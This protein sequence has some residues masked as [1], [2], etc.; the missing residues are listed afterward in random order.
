MLLQMVQG[1]L[2]VTVI[3][4]FTG[5]IVNIWLGWNIW[6]YYDMP[7]NLLGQVCLP[8]SIAWL[9]LSAVAVWAENALHF[10]C[11]TLTVRWRK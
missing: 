2:I 3:E 11:D 9:F 6:N 1:A 5:L 10:V 4:F 7:F 8:F